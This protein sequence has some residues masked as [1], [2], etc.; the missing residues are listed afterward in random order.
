MIALKPQQL[1]QVYFTL[2][3]LNFIIGVTHAL[4]ENWI[5]AAIEFSLFTLFFVLGRQNLKK[6]RASSADSDGSK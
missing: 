3:G 2:S 6:H 5:R 4:R 1:A